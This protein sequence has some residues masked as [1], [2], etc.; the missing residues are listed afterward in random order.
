MAKRLVC[1]RV[2]LLPCLHGAEGVG[3]DSVR[4]GG[5]GGV[6]EQG[7]RAGGV[8]GGEERGSKG[9][10]NVSSCCGVQGWIK[11]LKLVQCVDSLPILM[12]AGE[13]QGEVEERG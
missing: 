10:G 12:R 5:G 3:E 13:G 1:F 9:Q 6:G 7:L 4:R 11:G 2:F 8:A